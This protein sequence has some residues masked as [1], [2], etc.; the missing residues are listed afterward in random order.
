[1]RKIKN[2]VFVGAGN[3]ATQLA[4]ALH[5]K[6]CRILQVYSR[7]QNSAASLA[8]KVKARP[9]IRFSEISA[10]TDLVI[11]SVTDNALTNLV[12]KLHQ[13]NVLIVHTSGFHDIGVLKGTSSRYGVLYPLQTFSKEKNIDFRSIPFCIEAKNR[14]DEKLL[15][16]LAWKLSPDV[17]VMDSASRRIAHLAAVFACNYTNHMYCVARN[18]LAA[19]KIPFDILI[20]LITETAAKIQSDDP[21]RAQT[22]PAKRGDRKVMNEHIKMI[23]DE[24]IR[25][26][27][28]I[29]SRQIYK[30][31]NS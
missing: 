13:K 2:I 22:G 1:M 21:C 6:G 5:N 31:Y 27:Y 29:L 24:E 26:L 20:P 16:Q 7:T 17:R 3:V 28:K 12:L 9:I 11:V 23:K 15:K 10:D 4:T 25:S 18:I 30:K 19:K 14:S 8:K